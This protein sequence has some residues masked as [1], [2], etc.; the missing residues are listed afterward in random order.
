LVSLINDYSLFGATDNEIIQMLSDKI[1]KKISETLFYHLKKEAIKRRGDSEQWLDYYARYQFVEFY[2]TRIEE[3]ELV[4]RQ[5]LKALM[6]ETEKKEQQDKSLI[7]HLAKTIADNSKVLSEFGMAPP[8]VSK[9][10][11]MIS[12]NY[13][14]NNEN[15][16]I[17]EEELKALI[18]KPRA[19]SGFYLP[20]DNENKSIKI[21]ESQCVF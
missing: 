17:E 16:K 11:N 20:M 8:F 12:M 9:I 6:E 13:S 2:R 10:K 15:N 3:L 7:N 5:L 21:N 1:G 18:E 4:Q 19:K 14:N